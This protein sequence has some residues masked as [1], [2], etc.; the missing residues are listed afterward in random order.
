MKMTN[1]LVL[2]L[3]TLLLGGA[4]SKVEAKARHCASEECACEQALQKDTVDA[5]EDFLRKYPQSVNNGDSA[6][7]ALAIPPGDELTA[8]ESQS[9]DDTSEEVATRS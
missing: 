9:H 6:C 4:A 2:V 8:P 7:G 1:Y 3:G 5:L